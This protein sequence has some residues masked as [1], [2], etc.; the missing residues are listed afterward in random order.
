MKEIKI[1]RRDGMPNFSLNALTDLK[2]VCGNDKWTIQ[3]KNIPE[4]NPLGVK[5]K[6]ILTR[7]TYCGFQALYTTK[8]VG[9]TVTKEYLIKDD[10][11]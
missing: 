1:K 10:D 2:C 4:D 8:Y 6:K 9:E 3:T 5:V 11:K 7:C